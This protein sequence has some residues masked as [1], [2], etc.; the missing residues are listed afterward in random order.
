MEIHN[1]PKDPSKLC[2]SKSTVYVSNFPFNL[3]NND[4]HKL[5][6][7]H[8][9]IV[10]VTI[11]KDKVY[12]KSKGIAFV[13]FLKEEDALKCVRE[14][15]SQEMFGRRIKA[16]I[17]K[18][19]GRHTEFV[20]KK[21]YEDKSR[22]FECGNFSHLSYKCPKNILGEREVPLKKER[23]LRKRKFNKQ[24]ED[25][26][27]LDEFVEDDDCVREINVQDQKT[28]I[29]PKSKFKKSSYFS[30]EEELDD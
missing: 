12:R 29:K 13:N 11:V 15:D 6:E 25:D 30:D 5:F 27:D 4:L 21:T 3:T 26:E 24:D 17:A 9:K 7:K 1:N 16:S 19:N 28:F 8:G 23:F 18:D 20:K 2:P 22:C 10:K 14:T